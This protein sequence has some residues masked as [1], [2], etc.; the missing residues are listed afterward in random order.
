LYNLGEKEIAKKAL[1]NVLKNNNEFA[2][3]HALNVIDCIDEVSPEIQKGVIE[4]IANS[5]A[6]SRNNYDMRAAKWLIE[7]WEINPEYYNIKFAW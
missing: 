1:L 4:M 7:K 6:A 3:C 5:E 2:R